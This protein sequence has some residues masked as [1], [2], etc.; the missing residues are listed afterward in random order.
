MPIDMRR[1]Q[2]E[3]QLLD[4]YM[5]QFK[6]LKT[7]YRSKYFEGWYTTA[8]GSNSYKL[9]LELPPWY[10]NEMPTLCVVSPTILWKQKGGSINS[11]GV[12]HAFHTLKNG[13]GGCVQICHSK[14]ERWE[15]SMTC[16]GV[17][18]RGVL[19]L[20]AYDVHLLTGK[21]IADILSKWKGGVKCGNKTEFETFSLT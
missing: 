16:I 3:I 4:K 17:F 15:A 11:E 9:R 7:T 1:L 20:E 19:W 2:T 12:T 6:F 13:P 8:V 14:R 5:P 21:D 10:P 18:T